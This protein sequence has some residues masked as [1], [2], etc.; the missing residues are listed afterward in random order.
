[1]LVFDTQKQTNVIISGVY[2]PAQL[3]DKD[4]FWKSLG[5]M[6]AVVDLPWC[7]IGD[8]NELAAPSE[9]KGGLNY[10][11]TKFERLNRF[12]AHIN[13]IS[14]PF[15]GQAF[16]WKNRIHSHLIYER[17]DRAI[18]RNDWL[19]LYPDTIVCHGTFSCSDH[20]PIVLSDRDPLQRR[21]KF[22]FRFQNYWCQYR[23]LAPI[24]GRQW[25]TAFPGTHMFKIAQKL[26]LTKKHVRAW[27]SQVIGNHDQK[28]QR[29]AQKLTLVEDQLVNHPNSIRLNEWMN[30]LLQQREKLLLFNQKYWG[31]FRRK[32]WLVHGDHSSRFFPTTSKYSEEKEIDI[33]S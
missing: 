26:K 9:K 8:F 13:A 22:P 6:N 5:Q 17:L 28:L 18:V 31:N 32:E 16:T 19:Q 11:Q 15:K 20:C 33:L 23:Q 4:E 27:A 29:N 30:R 25:Q 10:S 2:G 1:M 21:K 24:I 12:L 14:V 3:M 7:I